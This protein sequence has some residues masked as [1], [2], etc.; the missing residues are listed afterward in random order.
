MIYKYFKNIKNNSL[1]KIFFLNFEKKK[2]KVITYIGEVKKK[3]KKLNE[4]TLLLKTKIGKNLCFQNFNSASS[5]F[6]YFT[7]Y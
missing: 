7:V 5:Y 3:K 6:L 1:V 4:L 2:K